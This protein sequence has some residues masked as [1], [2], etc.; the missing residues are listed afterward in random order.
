LTY[1][2]YDW[3]GKEA[4]ERSIFPRYAIPFDSQSTYKR[5]V[6]GSKF[7]RYFLGI[8]HIYMH[9]KTIIFSLKNLETMINIVYKF[10]AYIA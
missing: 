2:F 9:E 3:V 7:Q 8:I 6:P 1:Q 4:E 5:T 10:L